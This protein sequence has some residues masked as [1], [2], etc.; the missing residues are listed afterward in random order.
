MFDST[1]VSY[2]LSAVFDEGTLKMS[3][4]EDGSCVVL[5]VVKLKL[6]EGRHK[7]NT[8]KYKENNEYYCTFY[9]LIL[10]RFTDRVVDPKR[11]TMFMKHVIKKCNNLRGT[12]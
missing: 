9:Y 11:K 3:V 1:F 5:D 4:V 12:N 8:N 6:V 7:M 10:D 2:L